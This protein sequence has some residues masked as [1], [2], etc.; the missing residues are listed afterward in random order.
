MDDKYKIKVKQIKVCLFAGD[1][2]STMVVLNILNIL[3]RNTLEY[4]KLKI[5][6]EHC[7]D[8]LTTITCTYDKEFILD[9]AFLQSISQYKTLAATGAHLNR[10]SGPNF[11]SASRCLKIIGTVDPNAYFFRDKN[12]KGF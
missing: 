12:D 10:Y 6:L 9:N 7:S 4:K 2:T 8:T 5:S 1:T 3:W 11:R